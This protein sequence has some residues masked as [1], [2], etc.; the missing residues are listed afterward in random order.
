M[1]LMLPISIATKC[2]HFEETCQL[3]LLPTVCPRLIENGLVEIAAARRL[4]FNL[5]TLTKDSHLYVVS[6]D[7]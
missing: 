3:Q 4:S 7:Q 5:G 2:R 6:W 1:V